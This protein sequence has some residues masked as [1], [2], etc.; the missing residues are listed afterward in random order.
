M[1]KRYHRDLCV[2]D[3]LYD[4]TIVKENFWFK[5]YAYQAKRYHRDLWCV[6]D[7]LPDDN[8]IVNMKKVCFA[9]R[10]GF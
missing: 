9:L 8:I 2:Y 10:K 4:N 6:C 3:G 5:G 7:G 1:E